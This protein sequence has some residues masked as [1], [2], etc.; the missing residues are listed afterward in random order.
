ARSPVLD[1]LPHPAGVSMFAAASV[2]RT[3]SVARKEVL[4][5]F[6]DRQTL[7]MT[8][9]FPVVE[10]IMLGYAIDMNVRYI[11]TVVLDQAHTQE[12]RE[13]LQSLESS[14][15]F[16][17]IG[18]VYSDAQL[19]E[20]IVD[21]R[22]RVGVKIPEDYSR[23]LLA[24]DTAQVQIL[25][26]GSLS[27][28][29]G[30]AVNV[31]NAIALRDSLLRALGEKQLA[32]DSRPRVL[33]NPDMKSA[34]FF[35]PGLMV[36]LCQLMAVTLAAGAVVREKEKGTLEQLFMTPVR[37]GELIVGKLLP[38]LI[39]TAVEFCGIA[40]L[41]RVV[42]QVPINGPFWTLFLL[43]MPFILTMLAW[44]LWVSTR[45]STREAAMQTAMATLM[46]SIFLSGYVFPLDSMP[47]FFWWVA[48]MVPTT[49]MIDAS[50]GV[51]LR[52]AGWRE[53][54]PHALV[55]SGMAAVCIVYSC[56]RFQ[57]RVTT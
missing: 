18:S 35:I 30:E 45:V 42:F 38:Y 39:L 48:Q 26:D 34:N 47:P 6:R 46:P 20:A 51:I 13:L 50:R 7:M 5:I 29:A 53:L 15:D 31:G 43:M 56:M 1:S 14:E 16:K 37:P 22:A 4:H 21:G 2:Q 36:V 41:M 54:W 40:F 8:M 52:G 28:V 33:F 12:S 32:V 9:F 11:P 17:I 23:R 55:L 19:K 57:K 25:V 49:W 44:G 10:L 24:G 3:L 27:T